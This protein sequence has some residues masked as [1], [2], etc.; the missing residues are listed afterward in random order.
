[1]YFRA[2]THESRCSFLRFVDDKGKLIDYS[3][4]RFAVLRSPLILALIVLPAVSA[5]QQTT[6]PETKRPATSVRG[7]AAT[8]LITGSVKVNNQPVRQSTSTV[9][10]GDQIQTAFDGIARISAP[11]LSIYLPANS[12][13]SY[14]GGQL[15]MCN[16]GSLDVSAMKPVSVIY[17]ARQLVV[18]SADSSAAFS[19]SVAG[20]DLLLTNRQGSAEIARKGSVLSKVTSTG[21]R[22]FAGLGCAA[23]TT[24]ISSSAGIAAAA[25]TPA[26]IAIA[27]IKAESNRQPLSSTTP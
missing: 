11:G 24:A 26:A 7:E 25:A 19:V 5:A 20:H 13:I 12:C 1:M 18:S 16:C 14:G 22:S 6:S 10:Q 27:L 21:S 4:H 23:T 15:D 2:K 8:L 17:R 9:F 3:Q